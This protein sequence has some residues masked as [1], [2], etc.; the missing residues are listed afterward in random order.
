MAGGPL[1][2]SGPGSTIIEGNASSMSGPTV[3]PGQPQAEA[4]LTR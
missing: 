3:P 4:T 2:R 1:P